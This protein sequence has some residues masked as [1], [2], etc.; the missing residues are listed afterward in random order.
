MSY[1]Q[2]LRNERKNN[3]EE[4]RRRINSLKSSKNAKHESIKSGLKHFNPDDI[5]SNTSS[6]KYGYDLQRSSSMKKESHKGGGESYFNYPSG[7]IVPTHYSC[8]HVH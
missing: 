4:R 7:Y 1:L 3:E 2:L 5:K 8:K 6:A